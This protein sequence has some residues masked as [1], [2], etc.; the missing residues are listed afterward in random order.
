[1]YTLKFVAIATVMTLG[2]KLFP[3]QQELVDKARE[4]MAKGNKHLL[5]QSPAGSG[6]SII[7]ADMVKSSTDKGNHVLFIVHRQELVKQIEENFKFNDVNPNYLTVMT[8]GRVANR[9]DQL[10]TPDLIVTDETHHARAKTYKKI[11]DYFSNA[12]RIG[13]TATPWRMSGKGFKDIYDDLVEGK[14]VQWLIDHD[15]LSDYKMY[16][17]DLS[18]SDKLKQNHNADFTKKSMDEALGK[19]I[20]GDVVKHYKKLALG[21]KTILYAHSI[22]ASQQFANSFNSK[23]ISAVHCDGKTPKTERERIMTDFKEGKVQVLCNVDLISEGFNVPD[24]SCV[25]MARPTTSLVLYIQQSMRCM[26]YQEGKEAIII[27]HVGNHIR[28]GTPRMNREW[29]LKDREK[30]KSN[31]GGKLSTK[32][33]PNCFA[34]VSATNQTCPLCE[35]KF[36]VE[37]RELENTDDELT[38]VDDGIVVNYQIINTKKEIYDKYAQ[39]DPS[40]FENLEDFYLFAKSKNMKEGWIKYQRPRLRNMSWQQFNIALKPIKEKYKKIYQ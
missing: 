13:F 36:E 21:R 22:E 1:M 6:K 23:G 20:F 35:F 3:D 12:Y 11:Y 37:K 7:I 28:H 26:R 17:I 30:K 24:C 14:Q 40:E 33:C 27:D 10:P 31:K 5:I 38:L 4:S 15:R 34:V 25:I 19:S 29:T 8:V 9:L 18:D 2:Y 39:A 16:S 32:E